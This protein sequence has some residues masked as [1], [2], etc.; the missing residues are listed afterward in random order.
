MFKIKRLSAFSLI[1]V[2][3]VL[4]I[5]GVILGLTIPLVT[6]SHKI[7]QHKTTE[8][9]QHQVVQAIA[10]YVLQ[11]SKFPGAAAQSDG[12]ISPCHPSDI[13]MGYVPYRD[14][15]L[16]ESVARD[17]HGHWMSYAVHRELTR[18]GSNADVTTEKICRVSKRV[19]RIKSAQ[20]HDDLVTSSMD[21]VAFVLVSHAEQGR[22]ALL[23]SGDRISSSG[24]EAE[25]SQNSPDFY[26][27]RSPDN[28]H[29][30]FWV[31]RNNFMAIY[32]KNPCNPD[33]NIGQSYSRNQHQTSGR[34]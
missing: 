9:H 10:A 4:I 7:S 28:S 29:H 24:L 33:G 20:N 8:S 6:S 30:L 11:H 1:E 34:L 23:D 5:L 13:C 19:F 2:A 21:P 14:L 25:N 26:D 22:G 17:G 15:G 32:A 27:G 3:V 18:T 16:P 31:T 12:K